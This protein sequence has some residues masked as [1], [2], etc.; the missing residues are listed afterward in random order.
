LCTRSVGLLARE[1]EASGITTSALALVRGV[2]VEVRAP[3]MLYLH[4]PYGHAMGEPD[5]VGQQ[6]AVLRDLLSM[7]RAAPRAGLLVDLPYR[8][9]RES[10]PPIDDWTVDSA[11]FTAALSA[12]MEGQRVSTPVS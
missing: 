10:Y 8:W 9:R 2:A 3:R 1:I 6:R 11:A 5:N 4:W 7:A 12:A